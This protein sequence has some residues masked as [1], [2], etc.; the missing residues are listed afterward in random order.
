MLTGSLSYKK[1]SSDIG[2]QKGESRM[3]KAYTI[4]YFGRA[5]FIF[6]RLRSLIEIICHQ[7]HVK[8]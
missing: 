6:K 7:K 3:T 2:N 5:V 8:N 4:I 1:E